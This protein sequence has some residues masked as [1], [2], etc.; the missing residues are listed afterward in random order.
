MLFS[1]ATTLFSLAAFAT[2]LPTSNAPRAGGPAIKPIPDTCTVTDPNESTSTAAAFVPASS[3]SSFELYAAYYPSFTTN[4]TQM[5]QQCLEQC[6]GYGSS[7]ECKAA[8]WAENVVVPEGQ[9]GAGAK[10]TACR[11]FTRPLEAGDFV[12]APEGEATSAFAR[13]LAC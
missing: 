7:T 1:T 4:T 13:N 9:R 2:A 8:F 12:G 3:T 5:Q 6:Y 11:M 10:M